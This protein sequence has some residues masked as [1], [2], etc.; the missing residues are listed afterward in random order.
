MTLLTPHDFKTNEGQR[1]IILK[2]HSLEQKLHEL[3]NLV[4]ECEANVQRLENDLKDC[5][6]PQNKQ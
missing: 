1:K 5:L 2:M 3:N 4:H 6:E